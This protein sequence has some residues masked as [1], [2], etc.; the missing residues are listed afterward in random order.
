[1]EIEAM[2]QGDWL[3]AD[4]AES[5]DV[6]PVARRPPRFFHR[7]IVS[8]PNVWSLLLAGLVS[9]AAGCGGAS[10]NSVEFPENPDP[11]PSQSPVAA[12]QAAP[13]PEPVE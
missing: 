10:S 1:L 4:T 12:G 7:L 2:K 9:L 6:S 11:M 3:R 5:R 8:Q 13:A